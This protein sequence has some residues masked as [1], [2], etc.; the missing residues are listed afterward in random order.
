MFSLRLHLVVL[1]IFTLTT[2]KKALVM[3]YH[4]LNTMRKR[5]ELIWK[6][7]EKA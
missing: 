4:D 2:R 3:I 5:S 6:Q 1:L 7:Y